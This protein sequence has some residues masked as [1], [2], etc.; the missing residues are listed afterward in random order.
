MSAIYTVSEEG[1]LTDLGNERLRNSVQ[2]PIDDTDSAYNG[3]FTKRGGRKGD[4]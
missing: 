2:H 4:I 1:T 3:M